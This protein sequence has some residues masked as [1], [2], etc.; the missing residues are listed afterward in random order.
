MEAIVLAAG[1]GTRLLPLTKA[2]PKAAVP[3]ANRPL[4]SYALTHL[5]QAGVTHAVI[6]SFHLGD[7]LQAVLT[8]ACPAE[9]SLS[10]SREEMLLGTGGG[11]R[12]ARRW[13]RD[14]GEDVVVMNADLYCKPDI[15][16]AMHLHET[17]GALAT[18]V[19]RKV[20]NPQHFGSVEID[21]EGR[22]RR[23]LG[24]PQNHRADLVATMFSGV[25]ILSPRAFE[26]LPEE[27][28]VIRRT[29]RPWVDA[30]MHVQGIVDANPWWDLGTHA[31]YHALNIA[32]A[33]GETCDLS[34]GIDSSGIID[35]DANIHRQATVVDSVVGA[36]ATLDARASLRRCVVWPGTQVDATHTDSILTPDAIIKV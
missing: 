4:G 25:H 20:D 27:G 9:L 18:M 22:V 14:I 7:T 24:E 15:L 3:L 23:L 28:C 1:K 31:A 30:N 2:L 8:E 17:S 26:D 32:M 35:R 11:L 5:A 34:E 6:N 33:R 10:F 21:A 13:L 36:N 19:L 29:Y 16:A 12:Q